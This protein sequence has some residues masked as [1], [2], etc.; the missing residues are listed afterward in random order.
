MKVDNPKFKAEPP[1]DVSCVECPFTDAYGCVEQ[2][3]RL[4]ELCANWGT[5]HLYC[6]PTKYDYAEACL[7]A[8][9]AQ[10]CTED[11]G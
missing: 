10:A 3:T 7:A 6:C 1:N 8:D 2:G 9:L 5:N 4:A 11:I